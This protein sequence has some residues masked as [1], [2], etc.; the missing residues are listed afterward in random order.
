MRTMKE[1]MTEGIVSKASLLFIANL[2]RMPFTDWKAYKL[3]VIDQK[4]NIIKKPSTK[5]E[6]NAINGITNIIRKVKKI[7]VKYIGDSKILNFLIAGYILKNES[8]EQTN[9]IILEINSQLSIDEQNQL[10]HLLY[11]INISSI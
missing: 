10:E 3:G 6:K 8:T 7:L 11:E 2:F 9:D 1:I 4:G 5:E